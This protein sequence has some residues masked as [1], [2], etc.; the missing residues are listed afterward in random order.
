MH[1]VGVER[2][3]EI[4]PALRHAADDAGLGGERQVLQHALLGRDRGDALGHADAEIDDAARR[5]LEGAAARDDLALVERQ[6]LD[7]VERHLLAARIGVVV[8]RAVG[9]EVVLRRARRRRSRRARPGSRPRAG[10]SESAAAMRSTCAITSPPEFFA[11]IAEARL[12]SISA[13]RSMVMLPAG[14]AVVPRM[15]AIW[16]GKVL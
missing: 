1:G 13:S 12:S 11:A 3:A 5:Q 7:P 2:G 16:I 6:R 14:S 10:S 4:E 9:L 15:S 8:G